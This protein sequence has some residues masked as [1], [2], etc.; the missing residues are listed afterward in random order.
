MAI[1]NAMAR[2]DRR[3]VVINN[4]NCGVSESRNIGIDVA[5]GQ[6]IMFVD[7]DD[8]IEKCTCA[9]ALS[10]MK[11]EQADI[12]MWP[13]TTETGKRST[14]K[15]IFDGKRVFER[16]EVLSKLQRRFIGVIGEELAHPELAD[17]LCTVWGK[18]YKTC[19]LKNV[20]FINL[21][22]IGTYEDG[23]FNLEVFGKANKVVYIPY[24]LYH[25]RR[26]MGNTVTSDYRPQLKNQ[27]MN[28]FQIMRQYIIDHD[29]GDEYWEAYWN[30]I[31]LSV[32][33]LGLNI[34]SSKKNIIKKIAEIHSILSIELYKEAYNQ[35]DYKYFPNHWK[36]FYQCAKNDNAIGLFMLLTLMKLAMR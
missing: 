10:E 17:A 26:L 30:R 8:W 19:F 4:V 34:I 9:K 15:I 18:L 7:A 5:T 23:L 2:E 35:L 21:D 11:K 29:L 22:I 12:V 25:Y 24:Q 14:P 27:W 6:Y 36:I 33:G 28:L 32:L 16:E 20:Q 13:Y 1:L 3:I 31:G